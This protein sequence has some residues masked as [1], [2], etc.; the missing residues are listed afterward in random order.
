MTELS[1]EKIREMQKILDEKE[2]PHKGC[3]LSFVGKDGN[4]Y[5]ISEGYK[6]PEAM[7][8]MPDDMIKA[9]K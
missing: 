7:R 5:T 9:L 4:I 3:M 8:Q 1:I 2:V 6:D